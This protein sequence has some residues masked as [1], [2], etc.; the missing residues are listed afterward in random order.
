M[1]V[2]EQAMKLGLALAKEIKRKL[3]N[4]ETNVTNTAV[5]ITEGMGK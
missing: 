2:P 4:N 5:I 3:D 1:D